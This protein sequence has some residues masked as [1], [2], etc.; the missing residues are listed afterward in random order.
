MAKSQKK[1]KAVSLPNPKTVLVA[2]DLSPFVLPVAAEVAEAFDAKLVVQHVVENMD[3]KYDFILKDIGHKLEEDAHKRLHEEMLH[4]GKTTEVE[5]KAQVS[6]GH[7]VEEVLKVVRHIEPDLVVVGAGKKDEGGGH[8]LGVVAEQIVRLAPSPVL[9]ARPF[10]SKDITNIVVGLDGSKSSRKALEWALA[11]AKA[12]KLKQITVLNTYLVPVG[13][14]EAGLTYD[15]AQG[16]IM[17]IHKETIS[18][19]IQPYQAF[20]KEAGIEIKIVFELGD[21]ARVI[22]EYATKVKADLVA[23]GSQGRTFWADLILGSVG[24]KVARHCNA[25][26]LMVKSKEHRMNLIEALEKL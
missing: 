7:P 25:S 8:A 2:T 13:Y 19:V 3:K 22:P 5:V 26:V 20:A 12:E 16:K 6:H 10:P 17:E 21:P 11:L 14:V 9:I 1:S 4:L 24:L 18:E 23:I 15:F